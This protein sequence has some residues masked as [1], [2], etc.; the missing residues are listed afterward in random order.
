MKKNTMMR[1]ASALLV[2]VLLST[3]AI[4]GT[5]AK[6]VTESSGIDS[7]RVAK[8]GVTA[9]VKGSLFEDSYQD[10]PTTF[11]QNE[12][13]RDITVQAAQSTDL[14]APGTKNEEGMTFV[15]TG[16]PEVDVNVAIAV[17]NAD[18]TGAPVDVVLPAGTYTDYTKVTGTDA[19][20]NPTYGTFTLAKDYHPLVFTLT[21]GEYKVTGTLSDIEKALEDLSK[22][23][24][25]NT[26]LSKIATANGKTGNGT[27][28]LTWDWAFENEG[29]NPA[30][31]YLGNVAAELIV[32]ASAVTNVSFGIKITATQ[33]D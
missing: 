25:T 27:Y 22:I 16:T 29:K 32:D 21:S 28:T 2:A 17:T 31:T 3:C 30:D 8:W 7:A 23:Y 15:L 6:Y 33:I 12:T 5:F 10:A 13:G 4:S 9:H 11:T 26:D 20:G 18:E 24:D 1:V 19:S 14:V